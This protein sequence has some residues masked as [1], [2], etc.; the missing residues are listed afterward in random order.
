MNLADEGGV[1]LNAPGETRTLHCDLQVLFVI[2]HSR[3]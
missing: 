1:Y 3:I 2:F